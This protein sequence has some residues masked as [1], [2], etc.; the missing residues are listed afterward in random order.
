MS[1]GSHYPSISTNASAAY[2]VRRDGTITEGPPENVGPHRLYETID[3][4]KLVGRAFPASPTCL[5][6][7]E[8]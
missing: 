7:S 2:S 6:H 4:R 8:S 5:I 3:F 1:I